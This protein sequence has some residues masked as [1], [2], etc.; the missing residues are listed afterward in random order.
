MKRFFEFLKL[1]RF[2]NLIFIAITQ[3]VFYYCIVSPQYAIYN[4]AGPILSMANLNY[5]ILASVLIAAAGYIINDYF[6]LNIDRINKPQR[7]IIGRHISRRWAM[8]F[9]LLLSAIG[10]GYTAYVSY[11]LRNPFLLL[12]NII[13]VIVLIFYSTTFKRKLLSGNILISL[14][15]SWVIIIL[16]IAELDFSTNLLLSNRSNVLLKIYKIAAVYAG[17]AFVVSFIR[18]IVKDME[19]QDGDRRNKC[20]TIP[21]VWGTATAKIF[22]SGWVYVLIGMLFVLLFYSFINSWTWLVL[23]IMITLL[24]PLF[25]LLKKINRA[26]TSSDYHQLSSLIKLIM[27]AGI[28]SMTIYYYYNR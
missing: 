8:F 1:I 21:I 26:I 25:R 27:L 23:Y 9:H 18:E 20:S 5:L 11:D 3:L 13:V 14:L 24:L 28:F 19:D 12:F 6:D 7:L 4:S 10:L 15:T 22:V 16:Y 2:V 17:F